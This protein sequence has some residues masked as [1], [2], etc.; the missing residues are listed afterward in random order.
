MWGWRP[1]FRGSEETVYSIQRLVNQQ[2]QANQPGF[3]PASQAGI[4][5]Y[6]GPAVERMKADAATVR[7]VD[8]VSQSVI[9]VD[10]HS[11]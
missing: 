6:G 11:R 1:Y 7:I 8:G 4:G 2:I 3:R 9:E 5:R 10:H